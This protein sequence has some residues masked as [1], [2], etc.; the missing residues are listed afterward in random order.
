[1][2]AIVAADR[3]WG[4]GRDGELLAHI[5]EDMKYFRGKTQGAV[6]IMGRRTLES[7]PGGRPLKNR[8]NIVISGNPDYSVPGSVTVHSVEEAAS[9]AGRYPDR[10]IFVIGGG[11]IYRQMLPLCD[12]VL[13]TK[14]GQVFAADTFFPDLDADPEW[15]ETDPGKEQVSQGI[16]FRFSVYRRTGAGEGGR[17]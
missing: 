8:I 1:M 5:P 10:E 2:K 11:E 7:F 16:P 15:E 13:V 6:V 12:E 14:I 3:N 17:K 4:I 9:E